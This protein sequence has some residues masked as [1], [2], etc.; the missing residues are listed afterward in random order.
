M[1]AAVKNVP[2]REPAPPPVDSASEVASIPAEP[3][4]P[5]A[6]TYDRLGFFL[7]R[8]DRERRLLLLE[9]YGQDRR[10]LHRLHGGSAAALAQTAVR[11]GLL[12]ELSHAAYLGRELAKAET[13]LRF[14]LH[15]EQD[16][17]LRARRAS[18]RDPAGG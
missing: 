5:G 9:H 8:V 14:D 17:P 7:I 10:L 18:P 3:D 12:G 15:Y 13:A 16:S 11:L 1:L 2:E 6:W 4:R